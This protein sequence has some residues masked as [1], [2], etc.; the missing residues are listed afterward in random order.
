MTAKRIKEILI[1]AGAISGAL[2]AIAG[3][4]HLFGAPTVAFSSDISRLDKSQ[5]TYAVELYNQ[6]LRNYLVAQPPT[7]PAARQIFDED[8]RQARQQRDDA[9]KRRIELSK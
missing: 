1:Q 7:D 6:K 8:L 4:W 5:A 9:E 2:I 3:A